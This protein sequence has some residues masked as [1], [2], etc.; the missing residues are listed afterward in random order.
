M[1]S[2]VVLLVAMC[3]LV[4]GCS[5]MPLPTA[6]P[7]PQ[8]SPSA[9]PTLASSPSASG[10]LVVQQARIDGGFYIEGAFAYVEVTNESG[11]QIERFEDPEY[12]LAKEIAR[13]MLPAGG[14]T[15]V[16][17]V[18]P[19]E[20]ACPLLNGPRDRCEVRVDLT[21]GGTVE[22][23]VQRQVGQPCNA[24]AVGTPR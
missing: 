24:T 2:G 17:Y 13:V 20:A 21:P 3:T 1:K 15:V 6:S 14:Y 9:S 5:P 19:C 8:S 7:S 11:I 4:A 12:H 10:T 18:R 23:R 22:V 16:T